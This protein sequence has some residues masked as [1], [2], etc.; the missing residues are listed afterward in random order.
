MNNDI[1]HINL[2]RP[3]QLKFGHTALKTL[4]SLT[5]KTIEQLDSDLDVENFEMIEQLVYCGLLF[6]A[7]EKGETLTPDQIPDLLDRAPT[8]VHVIEKTIAAWRA[9]FGAPTQVAEGNPQS[10]EG[11]PANEN[12]S[13]GKKASE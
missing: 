9:A 10:P 4:V 13:T 3:R 5:G 8:F 1:I 12:R 2:D 6:D 7:K 11:R